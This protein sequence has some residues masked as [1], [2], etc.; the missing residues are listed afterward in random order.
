MG[1]ITF[2]DRS[3]KIYPE[4]PYKP[5]NANNMLNEAIKL[6]INNLAKWLYKKTRPQFPEQWDALFTGYKIMQSKFLPPDVIMFGSEDYKKL[7][8]FFLDKEI[9]L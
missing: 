6:A 9:T 5:V 2:G 1:L 8:D 3:A 4:K 7:S